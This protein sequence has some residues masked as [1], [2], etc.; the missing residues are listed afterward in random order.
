MEIKILTIPFDEKINGF[1]SEIIEDF[2]LNKEVTAIDSEFFTADKPYWTFVIKYKPLNKVD[3]N[4]DEKEFNL[5]K[6]EEKLFEA[7]KS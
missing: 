1:D 7:I 3:K 5:T 6:T 2:I 4:K